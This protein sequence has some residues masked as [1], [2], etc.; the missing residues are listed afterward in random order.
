MNIDSEITNILKEIEAPIRSHQTQIPGKALKN[1]HNTIAIAS[2]K[3]GVGKSTIAVNLAVALSRAGAKVGILDAD[4]YGPSIPQM[5][6]KTKDIIIEDHKYIPLEFHGI[7]AM[8]IGYLL[9]EDA[10]LIWR[11]PML[12]KSL[13][14]MLNNT[15]WNELDYLFIDLPPGTGDIQLSLVQKIPLTGAI[16]VTTG[17]NVATNDAE[18]AVQMFQKTNIDILGIIENMSLF[19]CSHCHN[20]TEIFSHGGGKKLAEKYDIPFLDSFPLDENICLSGEE[21]VPITSRENKNQE[22]AKVYIKIAL[23]VAM[24]IA[25]KPINY[26][27]AKIPPVVME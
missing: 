25:K 20:H 15:K 9:K 24:E 14:E 23:K 11:G 1:I 27:S 13:I 10:P 16:V 7:Q 8:S 2:G 17:Q 5:L 6:G 3:G 22:L 21:S 18:K 19:T 12:A 26:A 4:I